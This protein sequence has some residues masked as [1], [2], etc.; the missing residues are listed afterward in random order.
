VNAIETT[1][2]VVR[3]GALKPPLTMIGGERMGIGNR[4][5][6]LFVSNTIV[7][8]EGCR[9]YRKTVEAYIRQRIVGSDRY[10]RRGQPR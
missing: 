9:E 6:A 8:R 4:A 10:V 2:L 5:V 7:D 1:Q 3:C